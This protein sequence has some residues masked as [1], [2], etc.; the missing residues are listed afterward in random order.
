MCQSAIIK[1]QEQKLWYF[2][3]ESCHLMKWL[4]SSEYVS[5]KTSFALQLRTWTLPGGMAYAF[6]PSNLEAAAGI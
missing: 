1:E 4:S 3:N 5:H 2:E 6:Y